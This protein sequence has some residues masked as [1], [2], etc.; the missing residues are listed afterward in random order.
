MTKLDPTGTQLVYSTY[1]GGSA[2]DGATGISV[3]SSF[4]AYVTG[5][6]GSTDFPTTSGAFQTSA[7]DSSA[8]THAFA[9]KLNPTGSA[10]IYS[11]YLAGTHD[12]FSTISALDSSGYLYVAGGTISKDFPTTAGAFQRTIAG[13]SCHNYEQTWPCPDGFIAKLNLT[14]SGLIYSTYLG[15]SDDDVV[16][17]LAVDSTGS[18]YVTG[19]TASNDFPTANALQSSSGTATCGSTPGGNPR[20]CFFHAFVTKLNSA[21]TALALLHIL[22]REW[23]RCRTRYSRRRHRCRVCGG[24]NKFNKFSHYHRRGTGK[25]WRRHLRQEALQ[26]L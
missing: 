21:G 24:S 25:L 26:H 6:T 16:L 7:T 15:G 23:T 14:G 20:P 19:G 8:R 4:N 18:A 17:G 2:S 11:T 12:D 10:L 3:D 22:G 1:L 13:N 9:T 5:A